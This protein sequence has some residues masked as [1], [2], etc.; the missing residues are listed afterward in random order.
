LKSS[1]LAAWLADPRRRPLVMGVLNVAP[2]SFSDGGMHADP[3][4]ALRAGLAMLESGAD[5]IDIGGESTR[6]GALPVSADEQIRRTEPVVAAL[7]KSSGGAVISIDTSLAAVAKAALDAGAGVLNDITAG[8]GDAGMFALAARSAAPMILMHM[9]GTPRTMQ[10][11]PRYSDV[12][13]EVMGYLRARAKAAVDAG[14]ASSR[15]LIDPGIGFGKTVEHNLELLRRLPGL[16]AG[17]WPVVIGTSRKSFIRPI[18]GEIEPRDR[19]MGT[20]AS[21]AWSIANGAAVVRVHDVEPMV[22]VVR[23]VRAIQSGRVVE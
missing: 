6:P 9:L 8:T 17:G 18:T 12:V 2:D 5:W 15:L 22:R 23:M 4:S 1:D 16:V 13:A 3:E 19:V 21:V 20:A 11:D 7:A 10:I 14:V